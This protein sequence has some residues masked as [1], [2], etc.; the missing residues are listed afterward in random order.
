M[1]EAIISFPMLGEAF[2]INPPYCLNVGN[3]C[4]YFYGIIIACGL[5]LGIVY[6]VKNGRRMDI[7]P[8]TIYDLVIWAVIAAIICARAYYVIFNWSSY[9]ADPSKIFA[10][11]DGGLAIYGGVIGAILALW[12]RCRMKKWSIFPALDIM[13]FGLFI[14]QAIGRWGNFF[15]REAFGY[16]TDIFCRMGLTLNGNTMYVHPTFLYES[17]WNILGF[18]AMHFYSRKHRRYKGQFFLLYVFW[19]G[20]GRAM[21]EGL[22]TDSLWL[23]PD[24]IRVSQL[25]AAVTC[26]LSL[27]LLIINFRRVSAGRKPLFGQSLDAEGENVIIEESTVPETAEESAEEAEEEPEAAEDAETGEESEAEELS[28][29]AEDDKEENDTTENQE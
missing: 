11:R 14:G 8:D 17:L 6:G 12:V 1:R 28:E 10:I 23:V 18:A 16:E 7:E 5:L 25:L 15:N 20:L 24:V 22:R 4:I 27:A 29:A 19:Y 2:A 3:F 9:A 21:I 13:S 26:L